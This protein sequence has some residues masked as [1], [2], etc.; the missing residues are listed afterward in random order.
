MES[1]G[2]SV[3]HVQRQNM[4]LAIRA[5]S[6]RKRSAGTASVK[7]PEF[8][9][10]RLNP[11]PASG[12]KTSATSVLKASAVQRV[13]ALTLLS[14]D[15]ANIRFASSPLW[16]CVAA[17]RAWLAPN[18]HSFHL[19][20]V[21]RIQNAVG[22]MDWKI[23]AALAIVPR[24]G[25]LDF[26]APT[27]LTPFPTFG[28]EL[29]RLKQ[30]PEA[31]IRGEIEIAYPEG[32][33]PLLERAWKEP[34][35][36]ANQVAPLL[37]EFW[38]RAIAPSWGLLRSKLEG[39]VLFR[40]RALVLG[41]LDELFSGLHRDV[42]YQGTRLTVRAHSHWD[43]KER[44]PGLI[45]VPSVF[46]WPDVFLTVRSPWQLVIIY[47]CRGIADIWGEGTLKTDP[48]LKRLVGQSCAQVMA[49]L[50]VPHTTTEAAAALNRS[51]AAASEQITNLWHAGILERMRIG[52]RVFYSLNDKGMAV[53]STFLG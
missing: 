3:L 40:A 1:A 43:G 11:N 48:C 13:T 4:N 26:L 44:K 21:R 46:S 8:V 31:I 53:L 12:Q 42:T 10:I 30:V 49:T 6:I 23:L 5:Q 51:V 39:E 18:H 7:P 36:F 2:A 27:P 20:W 29:E 15:R 32:V 17:F 28:E 37:E 25:F 47:P 33:P 35:A 38:Q 34:S 50:Q 24:G 9:P 19:P 14:E 22:G 41:G 45:L 52:K 16:E